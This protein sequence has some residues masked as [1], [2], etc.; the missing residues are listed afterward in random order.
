MIRISLWIGCA[1]LVGSLHGQEVDLDQARMDLMRKRALGIRFQ[2]AVENFPNQL[3][4]EPLFRY[5]DVPRGYVDGTVWRLGKEGRP[6]AIITTELHPKYAGQYPRVVY[7]LLSMSAPPFQANSDDI[8]WNPGASAVEFEKLAVDVKPE[9][10]PAKRLFQMKRL[11]QR[12]TAHQVVSEEDPEEK[13]LSLRL[14]PRPIDRYQTTKNENSDAA[15][16]LFVA[17]R[18]PGVI[19]FLETDGTA[20]Q[21]GIGRLSAPSTLTVSFDHAKIWSVAPNFGTSG[22]PYNATNAPAK[23]PGH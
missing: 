4:T 7:D 17:G 10:T 20:W 22:T 16:F 1:A 8:N 6:H 3:S 12:F 19:V 15:T 2:S 9:S 11:M 18:M 14:L 5:D 23:I 13:Q 21:Y